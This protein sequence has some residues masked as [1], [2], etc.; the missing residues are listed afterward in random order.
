MKTWAAGF[1]I[2]EGRLV[3]LEVRAETEEEA[4]KELQRKAGPNAE[5]FD[6]YEV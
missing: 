2:N 4:I 6:L 1:V 3:F 5:L